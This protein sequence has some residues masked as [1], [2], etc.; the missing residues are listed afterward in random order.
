MSDGQTQTTELAALQR[1]ALALKEMRTKLEALEYSRSEPVAV[2]GLAC[3]MPGDGNTPEAF[4]EILYNGKDT[5]TEIP[6]ERWD[7][8]AYYDPTPGTPGKMYTRHAA[9]LSEVDQFDPLFFG[10]S[11]REAASMDPQQRLLLEVSWE[12]LENA[13]YAPNHLPRQSGIFIGMSETDYATLPLPPHVDADTYDDIGNDLCFASGRLAYILGVQGPNI[14]LDTAC[15]S[16]LVALHLAI[17][18]LRNDECELALAGGVHLNLSPDTFVMLAQ[19]RALSPDGRCKT[20]DETADGYGRGEGCGV[21]VLK[22]LSKAVQ[23]GDNILA[24]LRGSAVNHDGTSSG[25]TVPNKLAQEALLSQALGNANV[26][27]QEVSYVEAHGTGTSLGDPIEI[28]A[29]EAVYGKERNYPLLIGSVKTNIGHLEGA[30]GMAGII[31]VILSLQHGIIPAHL[32]L[33]QPNPHLDWATLPLTV[34]TQNVDWPTA[35]G[36][37]WLAGVSSFGLSGTNAH[38]LVEAAPSAT[39]DTD[40]DVQEPILIARSCHL[41]TLSAKTDD[42]LSA[43]AQ[44]FATHLTDRPE[45]ALAEVCFTANIGRAHFDHRLGIT[46]ATTDE[47]IDHLTTFKQKEMAGIAIGHCKSDTSPKVAFLFTGQGS[48]YVNMGRQLYDSQPIFRATLDQ[49]D[50]I[51]RP[52]LDVSLLDLLYPSKTQGQ[53]ANRPSASRHTGQSH[54]GL[55][56]RALID[57]TVYTQ[58]ALF[59]LEYALAQLWRSW[60]IEPTAVMGHSIGEYVAACVAGVF[61][62]EDGLK[63]VAERGRLMQALQANGA[64][65]AVQASAATV[66]GMIATNADRLSIAALNGPQSVVVSGAQMAIDDLVHQCQTLGIKMRSLAVSHAFHSSLIE[67]MLAEFREAAR[68]V[69]YTK[70]NLRLVSNLTGQLA[71]D[72]IATP[73]YWVRHARQPVQFTAGMA[74]LQTMGC[75]A[76]LEIGPQPILL[77]MGRQCLEEQDRVNEAALLPTRPS[78]AWLPSLRQGQDEWQILLSSLGQLYV[79]GA[80]VEWPNVEAASRRK[81]SLPT[82][83]FQRQRYWLRQRPS[84]TTGSM[85]ERSPIDHEQKLPTGQEWLYTLDWALQSGDSRT[86]LDP[87]HAAPGRWLIFADANG[88]GERIAALLQAQSHETVLVIPDSLEGQTIAHD[89]L[90]QVEKL[91][92]TDKNAWQQLLQTHQPNQ[93]IIYLWGT[94]DDGESDAVQAAVERQ[95]LPLLSLVQSLNSLDKPPLLWLVT[96]GAHMVLPEETLKPTQTPLWGLGRTIALEQPELCC[97]CID[98][99]MTSQES[100]HADL[101]QL[102][103]SQLSVT[104]DEDQVALRAGKRYVARL[105]QPEEPRPQDRHARLAIQADG[106]YLITGGSGGLGLTIAQELAARGARYLTLLS[107]RGITSA[108]AQNRIEELR[109]NGVTVLVCQADVTDAQSLAA[110]LKEARS[111]ATLRG[112]IHAAGILDD[113]ILLNQN[114]TRFARVMQPKVQGAW[115]LHTL[116]QEDKLDF[117]VCFSSVAA[118][119]GSIG[120]SNY[121]AAN[122]FLDGLAQFRQA[123][124]L[125]AL[126]IQWGPWA[127]VGMAA[128]TG[129]KATLNSAGLDFLDPEIG[130]QLCLDLL[131]YPLAQVGV[132]PITDQDAFKRQSLPSLFPRNLSGA[133]S[134]PLPAEALLETLS[135]LPP[136]EAE[137]RLESIVNQHV[138]SVLGLDDSQPLDPTQRLFEVG[139]DSLMAIEL[140]IRMQ[141]A[142]GC[143]LPSTLVFDYPS[144]AEMVHFVQTELLADASSSVSDESDSFSSDEALDDLSDEELETLLMQKIKALA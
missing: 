135:T 119:M 98:L 92:P 73:D 124:G 42:A 45:L 132:L 28:R 11:P 82:Y 60:G 30:A 56:E 35:N 31:K 2:V 40:V 126:S 138:V 116:T 123:S 12:A 66:E 140:R 120:Q 131:H 112:V 87:A 72:D 104:D 4:W 130:S 128:R 93:G 49:C 76:Y 101:A 33:N 8:D 68:Q 100:E 144:V 136:N 85:L 19:S 59:A 13:G 7:A 102:L 80:A 141:S 61:T 37:P 79:Q 75:Q 32:N 29:L 121:A 90:A 143:V 52:Y 38:I 36:Q 10:I 96:R 47:L 18:S 14:A 3:R 26:S 142:L 44:R 108:D 34:P 86:R 5:I 57:Q 1:A 111:V 78:I 64:M 89:S 50:E 20:F 6:T 125:P 97:T 107:R 55:D 46:A 127:E 115:H 22:R 103:Y 99:P 65:V 74:T 84:S 106:N 39:V 139:I 24:I 63:L 58:P 15:S 110:V 16:S 70:P 53:T 27:P 9:F 95:C 51:L 114:A 81:V 71:A 133:G 118:L 67:P 134:S 77:G 62:L 23:D 105:V 137:E 48:Q 91:D 122:A 109:A 17:Q 21:L 94:E 113:A 69:A 83:P 54:T 43:L 41:L 129:D 88:V 117:F 25:L